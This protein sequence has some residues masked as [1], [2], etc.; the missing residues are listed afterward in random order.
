MMRRWARVG[1]GLAVAGIFLALLV[2]RVDVAQVGRVL[3]GAAVAPLLLALVALSADMLARMARWWLMLRAVEPDLRFAACTRPFLASLALNNT[4]PFR[5]GDVARVVGFRQALRAPVAHVAGTLV[6]ERIL[7]LLT[8]LG[9]LFVSLAGD[10]AR[11]P[12][13]FLAAGA[14]AGGVALAVLQ[15]LTFAAGPLTRLM[16]DRLAGRFAG[17]LWVPAARRVIDQLAGA[18][19]LLRS[20]AMAARLVGLSLVAWALEGT[21]F[22]CV[23]WSLGLVLPWPAPWLALAAATLATLLPSTPGYVGTFDYFASLGLTVWGVPATGGAAFA[24]LT[25]FVLWTPVTA[26]GLLA[27][28]LGRVRRKGAPTL[29]PIRR[30]EGMP[31]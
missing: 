31:A 24:V 22:A 20:P 16:H 11:F 13:A 2:R 26:A 17:R 15:A 28:V 18:L 3:A 12:R 5:A 4:L 1:L 23:A 27:L 19:A 30:G 25:H 6:L 21:V 8:L 9:I 10:P 29:E 7:D 14:L